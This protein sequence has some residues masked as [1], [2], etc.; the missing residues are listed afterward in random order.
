[1]T[2]IILTILGILLAAAAAL[3]VIFYGGDAFNAGSIGAQANTLQNAGT[4][5]ISAVQ[6]QRAETGTA[7]SGDLDGLVTGKFLAEAPSVEGIGLLS[8]DISSGVFTIALDPVGDANADAVCARVNKNLK[9]D[10]SIGKDG[11]MGC[12]TTDNV[13]FAN[14]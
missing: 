2:T 7:N 1:M 13:F 5:V 9:R 14:L 3:M 10:A 8:K 11:K 4:N 12:D 6:L